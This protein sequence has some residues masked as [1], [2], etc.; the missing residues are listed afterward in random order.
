MQLFDKQKRDKLTRVSLSLL[1]VAVL[2]LLLI[3]LG[4]LREFLLSL[5]V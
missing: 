4:A 3:L 1:D 5:L 2:T